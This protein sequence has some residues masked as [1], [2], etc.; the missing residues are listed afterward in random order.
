MRIA[1]IGAG[2]FADRHLRA[3]RR[4]GGI[5]LVGHVARTSS[6]AES[7]AAQWGGNAYTT[8]DELLEKEKPEA[9]WIT[10]PPG[11]HGAIEESLIGAGIPFFVEKPLAADRDTPERIHTLLEEHDVIAAVGYHWRALDT[12]P[13]VREVLRDNGAQ[14][15]IATWFGNTPPPPWWHKQRDSGGQIVEQATHVIDIAR[16]LVGEATV[17]AA[18]SV[19]YKS[20]QYSEVDVSGASMAT[21]AFRSGAI[22]TVT[23]TCVLSRTTNVGVEFVCDGMHITLR[24]DSVVFD[25]Q[26]ERRELRTQNDPIV[27]EDRAFIDAVE[28]HDPGKVYCDYRDALTTHRL[29]MDIL[30]K[31]SD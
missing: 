30:D 25:S 31:S 24:Q 10:V 21:L 12:L 5:E 6:S 18:S 7:A 22:G 2:G 17:T 20:R 4:L 1:M 26:V 28:A 27:A 15:V 3:L 29:T 16:H 11:R 13:S 14:M 19:P 8:C 23:A 9:V